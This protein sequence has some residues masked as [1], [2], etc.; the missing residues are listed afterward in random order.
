MSRKSVISRGIVGCLLLAG[1][2]CGVASADDTTGKWGIDATIG[3]AMPAGPEY[4]GPADNKGWM[5]GGGFRYG[6]ARSWG[7]A[8]AYEDIRVND[9]VQIQP[10]TLS[11]LYYFTPD[12]R[13]TPY[14]SLGGGCASAIPYY[15]FNRPSARAGL[16]L[17]Y[18]F[19]SVL[20]GR[21][22]AAYHL[23]DKTKDSEVVLQAV[24]GG[25]HLTWWWGCAKKAEPAPAPAPE[26]VREVVQTPPP[27]PAPV[28]SDGDGVTDDK[29]K[30]PGTPA[31]TAVD[32]FGCP[33]PPPEP[34]VE[35]PVVPSKPEILETA[36]DV[37]LE[38]LFDSGKA[39]IKT[40]AIPELARVAVFLKKYP[41]KTALI[42]GH[43]DSTGNAQKNIALSQKRAE[44]VSAYLIGKMGVDGAQ[45]Q[46]KGF[47]SSKPIADN[48]TADGRKQNR[49]VVA[50]FSTRSVN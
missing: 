29:D 1:S 39:E 44:A 22:G 2:L 10:I 6:L 3:G 30:C 28:D 26:P 47:G 14:V 42:E 18:F 46:A 23:L 5:A 41:A 13:W 31:G 4:A 36:V 32:E 45:L 38:I 48:A 35:E 8:L 49:R 20:S 15:N 34:V 27:P 11:L 19:C 33:L 24:T 21:I 12:K 37:T 9:G 7:L 50:T 16:G 17:E 43:T 40:E 25:A